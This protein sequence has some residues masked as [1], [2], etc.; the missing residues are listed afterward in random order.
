M[1]IGGGNN[2]A[3]NYSRRRPEAVFC[4]ADRETK[5][6]KI[7]AVLTDYLSDSL[8][9]QRVLDLGCSS[10][11]ITHFL[12]R[13]FRSVTGLDIDREALAYAARTK[14]LN[15]DIMC[16]D[17]LE[18]PFRGGSFD[19]VICAHV[20]EHVAD[21]RR[22]MNEI[23]RVL[24]RGGVCFFAAGNR[25]RLVEPHYKLPLL[26]VLPSLLADALLGIS[27][28]GSH[29]EEKHLTYWGLKRL[30]SEFQV[31]DYTKKILQN[32]EE[33]SATEL[34]AP[35]SLKQ[36]TAILFSRL[37]YGLVPTYIFLL[38]KTKT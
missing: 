1:K 18:L 31:V 28:M 37:A 5:A 11:I 9:Q 3:E 19:V 6:K 35:G 10:G 27:G 20:Y 38:K 21:S 33:Y 16:A 2:L 12:C 32:P 34:C 30:V 8:E 24:R 13:H 22:L 17:A 26:S 15:A 23:Y 4:R 14:A 29:Y 25:L 36:K 7:L